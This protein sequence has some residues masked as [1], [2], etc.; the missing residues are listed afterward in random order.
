MARDLHCHA[1]LCRNI[2]G[3]CGLWLH[4]AGWASRG[5]HADAVVW[6]SFLCGLLMSIVHHVLLIPRVAAWAHAL[7]KNRSTKTTSPDLS[8]TATVWVACSFTDNL[9][10]IGVQERTNPITNVCVRFDCW[11]YHRAR[12]R[13]YTVLSVVSIKL[14]KQA[15]RA[16]G[17]WKR[18][19]GC[20]NLSPCVHKMNLFWISNKSLVRWICF[21]HGFQSWIL[22][23]S[24]KIVSKKLVHE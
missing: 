9:S 21:H 16:F 7:L 2:S 17:A 5:V 19:C 13:L 6:T 15:C 18:V 8:Q 11:Q 4:S 20:L 1:P 12:G 22:W 24:R 3:F 10:V 14:N 23:Y